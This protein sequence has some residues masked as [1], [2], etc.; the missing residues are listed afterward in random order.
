MYQGFLGSTYIPDDVYAR[1]TDYDRTK[2]TLQLVLSALYPPN[3]LQKWK[4]DLNWQP[5]PT[6]Y[7]PEPQDDLF[8][9]IY[10]CE[11]YEDILLPY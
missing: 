10:I 2:M 1:S 5:I 9:R 3:S 6:K 4:S 8:Q 11:S 7:V